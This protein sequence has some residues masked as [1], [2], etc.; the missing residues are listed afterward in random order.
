MS[1]RNAE[2]QYGV[3]AK[4]IGRKKKIA[5]NGG[6]PA[7][8][9][10]GG[11]KPVFTE[12][13]EVQLESY[14]ITANERLLGLARPELRSLAFDYAKRLSRKNTFNVIRQKA[15]Y[16]WV[17]GFL[18]RNPGVSFRIPQATSIN[19]AKAF[20]SEKVA[21]FYSNLKLLLDQ[22]NFS[23]SQIYNMDE[24]GLSI[25]QKP[26][27]VLAKRGT[28]SVGRITSGERGRLITAMYCCSATGAFI[29]PM[30]VFPGKRFNAESLNACPAEF[31][32]TVSPSG[33]SNQEVFVQ[34][35]RHFINHANPSKQNPALII[36]DNHT[37]HVTY[38]AV[39]VCIDNDISL[40]SLPPHCS[41]K[42]QPLDVA[43]FKGLKSSLKT[44]QHLWLSRHAPEVITEKILPRIFAEAYE[45]SAK[46]SNAI[47]GFK[48]AGIVPFNS[49]IFPPEEFAPSEVYAPATETET[50]NLPTT[51]CQ[52]S[53]SGTQHQH[54]NRIEV[55][56]QTVDGILNESLISAN[57]TEE[58]YIYEDD[59]DGTSGDLV[60]V[61]DQ[62]QQDEFNSVNNLASKLPPRNTE[63]TMEQNQESSYV[64]L[65]SVEEFH[66]NENDTSES[67][68]IVTTA[69]K[70]VQVPPYSLNDELDIIAREKDNITRRL[71]LL[72]KEKELLDLEAD[73]IRR[74]KELLRRNPLGDKEQVIQEQVSTPETSTVTPTS[75]NRLRSRRFKPA[76]RRH[77]FSDISE[78]QVTPHSLRPLICPVEK[79]A[80]KRSS[81]QQSS[82]ILTSP[83]VKKRLQDNLLRKGKKSH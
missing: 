72:Q 57:Q 44:V 34:W 74:E 23:P 49:N 11:Y 81:R 2:R 53:T 28:N 68:E 15:G 62:I 7:K 1:L 20:T 79:S 30:L 55:T 82:E 76:L 24:T 83:S 33:W 75:T 50:C 52:P 26:L 60:I 10:L 54:A 40:L 66:I 17:K 5:D 35:L 36:L 43:V 58:N 16:E 56:N 65:E 31:V 18:R 42:M 14:L 63:V 64:D 71:A 12:E 46:K 41:H 77:Y 69:C 45:L 29:P 27:P 38:E 39:H 61:V 3:P 51:D 59:S 32:G 67:A 73:I 21:V 80:K 4:T 37:S 22:T 6:D 25:V 78:C 13:E 8:V 70:I 47:S 9:V 19:R 48:A